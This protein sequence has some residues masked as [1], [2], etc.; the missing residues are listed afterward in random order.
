[1]TRKDDCLDPKHG[2]VER[3]P[4]CG[5]IPG[6][7]R[8]SGGEATYEAGVGTLPT[9]AAN[10]AVESLA[11]FII[12]KAAVNPAAHHREVAG[13][14]DV[15][16]RP[17][18]MCIRELEAELVLPDDWELCPTCGRTRDGAAERIRELEAEH[19]RVACLWLETMR[20]A[21]RAE[22]RVKDLEGELAIHRGTCRLFKDRAEKAEALLRDASMQIRLMRDH[23]DEQKARVKELETIVKGKFTTLGEILHARESRSSP[24]RKE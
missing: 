23:N 4:N 12:P 5:F 20:R 10:P 19:E 16:N 6:G 3:C 21:E 1:M 15:H 7:G 24:A 9:A 18:W 2:H 14:C 17:V 13:H 8:E 11:D 22:A